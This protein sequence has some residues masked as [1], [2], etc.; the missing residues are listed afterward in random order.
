MRLLEHIIWRGCSALWGPRYKNRWIYLLKWFPAIFSL[1]GIMIKTHKLPLSVKWTNIE[2]VS[3]SSIPELGLGSPQEVV[4]VCSKALQLETQK[5]HQE[6][7]SKGSRS[8]HRVNECLAT[9]ICGWR[10][11]S[12]RM[13]GSGHLIT[14]GRILSSSVGTV[15]AVCRVW[16]DHCPHSLNQQIKDHPPHSLNQQICS[17][18]L[19]NPG[20]VEGICHLRT[21][22]KGNM[23]CLYVVPVGLSVVNSKLAI[24]SIPS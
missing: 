10:G 11:R 20:P 19:S 13:R 14:R 3:I 7:S 5:P 17:A 1:C 4:M 9:G 2:P 8:P 15:C 12:R 22:E 23:L 16:K 6:G 18:I 24:E 21:L